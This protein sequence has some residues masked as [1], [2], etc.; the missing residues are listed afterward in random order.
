M[1]R[2]FR[3]TVN[4]LNPG[5]SVVCVVWLSR[6]VVISTTW[7]PVHTPNFIWAQSNSNL[8]RPRLIN[9]ARIRPKLIHWRKWD[10]V[11]GPG[12]SFCK[13]GRL[14]ELRQH[15]AKASLFFAQNPLFLDPLDWSSD[16][17]CLDKKLNIYF[18]WEFHISSKNTS[19]S[20]RWNTNYTCHLRLK[21]QA[22]PAKPPFF[23]CNSRLRLLSCENVMK[24]LRGY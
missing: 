8:G 13:Y 17:L 7:S 4:G 1:L 19:T 18:I 2:L 10:L 14:R 23:F 20:S 3:I 15:T 21:S 6:L 16:D 12:D 9:P 11:S 22:Y 5:V 24:I